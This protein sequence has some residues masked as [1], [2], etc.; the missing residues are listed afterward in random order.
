MIENMLP[1]E[2]E[3]AGSR[4]TYAKMQCEQLACRIIDVDV[5]RALWSATLEP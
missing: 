4:F 3:I 1:S 5:E 2:F